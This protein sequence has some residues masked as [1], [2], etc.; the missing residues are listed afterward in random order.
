MAHYGSLGFI[1]TMNILGKYIL[2]QVGSNA[3][4]ELRDVQNVY[5]AHQFRL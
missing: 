1:K 2:H 4:S 3:S 5:D